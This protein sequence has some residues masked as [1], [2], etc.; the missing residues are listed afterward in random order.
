MRHWRCFF[1]SNTSALATGGLE[2]CEVK[3]HVI[4]TGTEL[5]LGASMCLA[6]DS[7]IDFDAVDVRLT[8][9]TK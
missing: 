7:S 5:A 6:A 1:R 8:E 2:D 4:M 3:Q 9:A